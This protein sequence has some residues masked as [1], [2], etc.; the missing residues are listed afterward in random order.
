[1]PV[2]IRS[3]QQMLV[4]RQDLDKDQVTGVYDRATEAQVRDIQTASTM[5]VTGIMDEP[6]WKLFQHRSCGL[7]DF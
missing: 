5:P 1:M 6:T 4:D 7:Y 2:W 3:L